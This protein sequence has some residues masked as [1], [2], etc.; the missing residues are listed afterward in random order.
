M[1]GYWE[2]PEM[3][4]DRVSQRDAG[5]LEVLGDGS[6]DLFLRYRWTGTEFAPKAHPGVE[7]GDTDAVVEDDVFSAYKQKGETYAIW[8]TFFGEL[9]YEDWTPESRVLT[10]K[11]ATW[12][13]RPEDE[14]MPITLYLER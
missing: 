11:A 1:F 6:V 9:D 10:S 5:F 7:F 4:R 13:G 8:M 12:P 2:I 3:E 14:L